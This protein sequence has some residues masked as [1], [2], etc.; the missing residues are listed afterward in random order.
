MQIHRIH[1]GAPWESQVGYCRAIRAGDRLFVSGTA[2]IDENGA[3]FAPGDA[4]AQAKRCLETIQQAVR[5]LGGVGA[6]VVR[7][8]LFVTDIGRWAEYGRAHGEFFCENPPVTTMVEVRALIDPD[9]L[10][11]IEAEAIV[12]AAD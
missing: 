12:P 6:I 11:E 5:E 10:V 2:P 1:S 3:V 7:T 4:Y 8:R 9:M